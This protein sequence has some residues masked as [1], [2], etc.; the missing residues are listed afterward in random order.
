MSDRPMQDREPGERPPGRSPVLKSAASILALLAIVALYSAWRGPHPVADAGASSGAPAPSRSAMSAEERA[1]NGGALW[2][3]F[4]AACHNA[5]P[6]GIAP[7]GP[8]LLSQEYLRHATDRHID[9]L[10]THGVPGTMM[11]P[12]GGRMGP[13]APH[14]VQDVIA[15]MRSTEAAAPSDPRGRAGQTEPIR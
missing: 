4:C 7:L 1:R 14:D 8:M 12:W 15:F 5:P 13:L 11:T 10:I 2:Q 3:R 9:S 6:A